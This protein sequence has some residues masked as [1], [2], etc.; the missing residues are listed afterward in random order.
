[1]K[2]RKTAKIFVSATGQNDGKTVVSLGLICA[3]HE[4]FNKVGFI[5]P[6]GQRYLIDSGEKIDEEEIFRLEFLQERR[7][8]ECHAP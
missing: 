8:H 1:M 6:V 7:S 2:N 4:K 3:L 5:K